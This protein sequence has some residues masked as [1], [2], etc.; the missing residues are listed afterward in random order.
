M[1]KGGDKAQ[2]ST[3]YM[4]IIGLALAFVIPVTLVYVHY[5]QEGNDSITNT[6][7]DRIA[8]ELSTAI[9]T[10]Y[11]YGED[12]ETTVLMKLP[13]GVQEITF[14]EKEIVFKVRFSGDRIN[15]IVKVTGASLANCI[16]TKPSAGTHKVVIKKIYQPETGG[17]LVGFVIDGNE[18]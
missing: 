3:E 15:E 11:S 16:I 7:I 8:D 10:V 12:S 1:K 4:V 18:C 13:K 6:K 5:S 2:I 9:N 17:E 14:S